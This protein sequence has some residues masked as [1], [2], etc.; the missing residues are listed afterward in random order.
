[1]VRRSNDRSKKPSNLEKHP[2]NFNRHGGITRVLCGLMSLVPTP[3]L[4]FISSANKLYIRNQAQL[5]YQPEVLLPFLELFAITF[6]VGVLLYILSG[7]VPFRYA[8]WSYYL[9]GPFYLAF[10]FLHGATEEFPRLSWLT[11]TELGSSIFM[12]LFAATVIG[13]GRRVTLHSAMTPLAA[14]GVLLLLGEA[15]GF[16]D[17][18]H[19]REVKRLSEQITS[20]T[21]APVSGLP[22]IYHIVLDGFQTDMFAQVLSPNIEEALGGFTYFP[23]NTAIYHLS[24]VSLASMFGGKR[25]AYDVPRSEYMDESI[26]GKTSLIYRLNDQGYLTTAYLPALQDTRIEIA[27]Y[28][29]R[30]ADHA[31][32][33]LI[34][35]N[36]ASFRKL[37]RYSQIPRGLRGWLGG[38]DAQA[39]L[40]SSDLKRMEQGRFLPY[41]GP[42]V[43]ALSFSRLMEEEQELPES[44]RYSFIH[45][46]MP[47]PPHVLRGDCSY[48]EA[49]AK[50]DMWEQTRCTI[51]LLLEFLDVLHRLDR[52]D[53]SLIVVHGDH[54]GEYRVKNNVL[55]EARSRS[56]RA[57]L[58]VKPVGQRKQDG[59]QESSAATSLLD[60]VP[61]ILDCLGEVPTDRGEGKSLS[62]EIPCAPLREVTAAASVP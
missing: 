29:V 32:H 11:Y 16:Q 47:H 22:N 10:Q 61:T 15:W 9:V 39:A 25:Y 59:F 6:S 27:D 48:D 51:R 36:T 20:K 52:F 55:V 41:S 5:S 13:L 24:S 34:E 50:T 21:A 42:V 57:L 53:G 45:L 58:L 37:W 44:G 56:L 26:N 14:F 49:G 30:Q 17:A 60:I 54:G 43:S 31:R 7:Y 18:S 3:L 62:A 46:L 4:I 38:E 2:R 35:M 19:T 28:V 40:E 1:M 23:E 33:R 8:L 12:V